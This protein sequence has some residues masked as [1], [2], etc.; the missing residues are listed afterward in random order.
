MFSPKHVSLLPFTHKYLKNLE[1]SFGCRARHMFNLFHVQQCSFQGTWV[2]QL[3]ECL[4]L[5]LCSSHD[6]R[7]VGWSPGLQTEHGDCLE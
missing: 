7:A 3:V 6:L 1:L 2:V 4:T 5:D